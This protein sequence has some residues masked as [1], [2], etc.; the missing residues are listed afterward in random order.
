MEAA[1]G[2]QLKCVEDR[3]AN[4]FIISEANCVAKLCALRKRE[5]AARGQLIWQDADIQMG[6][7]GAE[8]AGF[9]KET[10]AEVMLD[11]EIPCGRIRSVVETINGKGVGDLLRAR[12]E[13]ALLQGQ[14]MEERGVDCIGNRKGWLLGKLPGEPDIGLLVVID[15]ITGA[16]D[17]GI[18]GPGNAPSE[19]HSWAPVVVIGIDQAG[20]KRTC[21]RSGGRRRDYSDVAESGCDVQICHAPIFLCERREEFI[22][23]A[24]DQGQVGTHL[25]L[26]LSKADVLILEKIVR[27]RA[28]A[29]GACLGEAEEKI[30]EII[31]CA[32]DSGAAEASRWIAIWAGQG[33]GCIACKAECSAAVWIRDC[34]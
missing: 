4:G 9:D 31:T 26:V 10:L 32:W 19:A 23:D 28:I 22:A 11:G 29:D 18:L 24:S 1:H 34:A 14:R 5:R 33:A 7:F 3:I 17:C 30:G 8:I 2:A 12:G 16:D 15:A 13:K 6:S 20:R 25:P 21:V 27:G